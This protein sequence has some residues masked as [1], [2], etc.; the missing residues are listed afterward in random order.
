MSMEITPSYE[1]ESGTWSYLVADTENAVAAIIDPVWVFNPVSGLADTAFIDHLLETAQSCGYR[2]EWVLET[3]AHADHLTAAGHIREK[4]GAKV[5]IGRDICSVQKTFARVFNLDDVA[6][7]GSQFDRLLTEGDIIAL[8]V[9]EIRVMETPGHTNDSLTYLVGNA[10]FIGDTLFTPSYGT[11]RCDFP[12]GNAARLYD[13]IQRIYGL[14]DDTRLYLCHDYPREGEKPVNLVPITESRTHNTHVNIITSR[15]AFVAMRNERDK[16]LG[17]PR[18][19]MASLQ[20]NI[21]GGAA[22]VIDSNGVSYLRTPFNRTIA[23]I[24]H[25]I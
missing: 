10:A 1:P 4:T 3:H 5:A 18:L 17:L 11:A 7:D 16:H 21:R 19:I 8:G 14:P 15:E 13:S 2:I 9:L 22:P 23:Q 24:L 25:G 12:G 20:V 6:T